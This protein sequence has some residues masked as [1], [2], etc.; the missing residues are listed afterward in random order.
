MALSAA[1]ISA[2]VATATKT[3]P[4]LVTK[5]DGER[6]DAGRTLCIVD[7]QGEDGAHYHVGVDVNSDTVLRDEAH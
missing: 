3:H 2:S 5:A 1:Q 7:V 6:D 4:G